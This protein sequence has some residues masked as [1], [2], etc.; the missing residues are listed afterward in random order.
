[1]SSNPTKK[2][3]AVAAAAAAAVA[4]LAAPAAAVSL[5]GTPPGFASAATGGG[6]ATPVYPTT[7]DELTSYLTSSDPQV[8]IL[9][10]TYNYTGS[11]GT[12]TGTGCQ[13]YGTASG[14]QYAIDSL[15]IC[16]S[17]STFSIEYDTAGVEGI[18]V[19]SQKTIIG[20]GTD[21]QIIGKGVS[22]IYISIYISIYIY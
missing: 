10:G 19:Q 1:M 2:F 4:H 12:T 22:V 15:G 21:T 13:P 14:C 6:D 7:I 8:I 18:N 9:S 16:D 3:A 5:T 11:E 17:S 20:T